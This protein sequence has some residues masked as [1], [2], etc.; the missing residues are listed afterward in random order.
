VEDASARPT[1]GAIVPAQGADPA[2]T[3]RVALLVDAEA[4]V[5][6]A[7]LKEYAGR[8]AADSNVELV[9]ITGADAVAAL[10]VFE[11]ELE[12]EALRQAASLA[13]PCVWVDLADAG[14][15]LTALLPE[16]AR[17]IRGRGIEG[18]RWGL[19]QALRLAAA[20]PERVPYGEGRDRFYDLR[21]PGGGTPPYPVALLV[22]G[23]FWRERWT[24]DT[25]EPLAV[26]LAQRG[27][28]TC[29]VEYRRVGL[30]GGGWPLTD[31]D[32]SAALEFVVAD[33]AGVFD[34]SRLVV[35][36]H[37]AGAQLAVVAAVRSANKGVR[38]RLVVSLAGVLDLRLC[39]LR[40]LG[41][42]G[43]AAAAYADG[44]PHEAGDRY[45]ASS[46]IE[47]PPPG[48]AQ[49][50]VQGLDDSPDLAE[51]SRRY[52]ARLRAAGDAVEYLELRGDHFAVITASSEIWRAAAARIEKAVA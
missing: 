41:D 33:P 43:N 3:K 46:P 20:I 14:R 34:T 27:F 44:S 23:G 4:D 45:E 5:D 8:L 32:V 16:D 17:L 35:V 37:S 51:M 47:L 13:I 7:W 9:E 18:L 31:E 36:G 48:L 21:L 49:L 28:A 6:L 40:G 12:T 2:S 39:A 26:D 42:T 30:S 11:S 25:I 24:L 50:V 15:P 1:E 52:V 22:H 19:A 10:V 38:P 29:N